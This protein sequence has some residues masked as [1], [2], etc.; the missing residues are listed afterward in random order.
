VPDGYQCILEAVPLPD[1][2]MD[3]A[4]RDDTQAQ[5]VGQLDQAGHAARIA[6]DQVVLQLHEGAARPEQARE[7]ACR[8]H[9]VGEAAGVDQARDLARTAARQR[10][11]PVGV[12]F[13]VGR[14]ERRGVARAGTM[15][16][17]HQPTEV[18]VAAAT[19][20]QEREVDR[21]GGRVE[22]AVAER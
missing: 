14:I 11:H 18:G 19:F 6:T 12:G 20:G 9:G 2:V 3:V 1:V 4:G 7:A 5:V 13:K 10:D 15:G 16:R 8:L 22:Q 21:A 17:G